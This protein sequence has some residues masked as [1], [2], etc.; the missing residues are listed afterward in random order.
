MNACTM[1]ASQND[2]GGMASVACAL[3]AYVFKSHSRTF[4]PAENDEPA[5][6]NLHWARRSKLKARRV[7]SK[8]SARTASSSMSGAPTVAESTEMARAMPPVGSSIRSEYSWLTVGKNSSAN[9]TS[10]LTTTC[11]ARP[12]R[13]TPTTRCAIFAGR[14]RRGTSAR[15]T[16][17]KERW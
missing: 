17:R 4:L 2:A 12:M 3:L 15:R 5:R 7:N 9:D 1:L 6:G 13:T 14:E 8:T 10:A 11:R 16:R